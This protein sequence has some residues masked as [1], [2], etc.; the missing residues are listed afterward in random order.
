MGI[1]SVIIHFGTITVKTGIIPFL[2]KT[3]SALIFLN[4]SIHIRLSGIK[5]SLQIIIRLI[6]IGEMRFNVV[7]FLKKSGAFSNFCFNNLITFGSIRVEFVKLSLKGVN[8]TGD[9]VSFISGEHL[10]GVTDGDNSRHVW[11]DRGE[12]R[13]INLGFV[14][15]EKKSV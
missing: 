7:N 6:L 10:S 11:F 8:K 5:N 3:F 2:L 13:E 4:L 15:C 9:M 14:L 12:I 1:K